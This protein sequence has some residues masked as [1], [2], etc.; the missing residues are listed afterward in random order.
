MG[1]EPN[2]THKC[3]GSQGSSPS[4]CTNKPQSPSERGLPSPLPPPPPTGPSRE[5]LYRQAG[6]ASW[7]A[8]GETA[9]YLKHLRLLISSSFLRLWLY[10]SQG[11]LLSSPP[12]K[13]G[14]IRPRGQGGPGVLLHQAVR[15]KWKRTR[16][17][18]EI[19]G[20]ALNLRKNLWT[21]SFSLMAS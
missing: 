18:T 4:H 13:P 8:D 6:L 16:G 14:Q 10:A 3:P 12:S 11:S 20:I 7:K 21:D 9:H 2:L 17:P 1:T 15:G 19:L 5:V